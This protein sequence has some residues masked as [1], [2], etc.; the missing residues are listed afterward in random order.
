MTFSIM[1]PGV[2][3]LSA[4]YAVSQLFKW[5]AECRY[6]ECRNAECRGAI[7]S[8]I[9]STF[10]YFSMIL[11]VSANS[12]PLLPDPSGVIVIKLFTAVSY[13]FS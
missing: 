8:T 12:R 1:T 6:V 9:L 4:R 10:D 11:S 7:P 3:E 5:Y 2:P 13:K